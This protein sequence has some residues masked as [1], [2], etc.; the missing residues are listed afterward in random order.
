MIKSE[1]CVV[2]M[3]IVYANLQN[4]IAGP[5]ANIV[6]SFKQHHSQ[7]FGVKYL[8]AI[9]GW[10]LEYLNNVHRIVIDNSTGKIH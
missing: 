7:A 3:Q 9:G 5:R 10:N 4:S 2:C 8:Y 6:D 1:S